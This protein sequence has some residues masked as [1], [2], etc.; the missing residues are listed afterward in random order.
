MKPSG[1]AY[2]SKAN[3]K[4]PSW[5]ELGRDEE[6][7][8]KYFE[9]ILGNMENEMGDER[10]PDT[11][12]S[13]SS[14]DFLE[15]SEDTDDSH[16]FEYMTEKR[17]V[18]M[19]KDVNKSVAEMMQDMGYAKEADDIWLREWR[20]NAEREKRQREEREKIA[21]KDAKMS[22]MDEQASWQG[23][24][25][26]ERKAPSEQYVPLTVLGPTTEEW[27]NKT[28]MNELAMDICGRPIADHP[29]RAPLP[30]FE[31]DITYDEL[32]ARIQE[33]QDVFMREA[34]KY[35][36]DDL[37][38]TNFMRKDYGMPPL[39]RR[40]VDVDDREKYADLQRRL[41]EAQEEEDWHEVVE[42]KRE[43]QAMQLEED[44]TWDEAAEQ[45]R[46]QKRDELE[47]EGM[48]WETQEEFRKLVKEECQAFVEAKSKLGYVFNQETMEFELRKAVQ[49]EGDDVRFISRQVGPGIRLSDDDKTID[50]VDFE[51]NTSSLVRPTYAFWDLGEARQGV[52]RWRVR[53][54]QCWSI[55]SLGVMEVPFAPTQGFA[56][57][58]AT[59]AWFVT[60]SG[61][62]YRTGPS[63]DPEDDEFIDKE[64]MT[65]MD[66]RT[67]VWSEG[68]KLNPAY[69]KRGCE[70]IVDTQTGEVS[71][72]E[73]ERLKREA[74]MC[75]GTSGFK[76]F[77]D[78]IHE[79]LLFNLTSI[80]LELTARRWLKVDSF[81]YP[82]SA[83][84]YWEGETFEDCYARLEADGTWDQIMKELPDPDRTQGKYKILSQEELEKTLDER[85]NEN[86][87][88]L[89][90]ALE[91]PES[92]LEEQHELGRR[93][94][95]ASLDALKYGEFWFP[96]LLTDC[97]PSVVTMEFD[98]S[99]GTLLVRVDERPETFRFDNVSSSARPFVNVFA[100]ADSVTLIK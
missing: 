73:A 78:R 50:R 9:E 39:V 71:W 30:A 23:D 46:K 18:S 77:V 100:Y 65:V 89:C 45:E 41:R 74:D 49:Y 12:P 22:K 52:S 58:L 79:R 80:G 25:Q 61:D 3:V 1:P 92:F 35:K 42:I 44:P 36:N 72:L 5:E 63:R 66:E 10:G 24:K 28:L 34:E 59:R 75:S 4:V 82:P 68:F 29:P 37:G 16:D 55:M 53:I 20:E 6:A 95:L 99:K 51:Q 14:D 11:Q 26:P 60:N 38:F 31:G 88:K 94:K 64:N 93:E 70:M 96:D 69:R 86:G 85:V 84:N 98:P 87:K 57:Q 2:E 21:T 83:D 62:A 27:K 76:R 7:F 8:D 47:A 19:M 97:K 90:E 40:P 48:Y 15:D 81:R 17:Y 54:N 67:K 56:Q 33:D 32:M 91:W 43:M 13:S